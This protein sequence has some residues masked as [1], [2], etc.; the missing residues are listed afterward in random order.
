MVLEQS[1]HPLP[2]DQP[3]L[4]HATLVVGLGLSLLARS[5]LI[6]ILPQTDD[7][8]F[9]SMLL[10]DLFCRNTEVPHNQPLPSIL[11]CWGS[12]FLG[13]NVVV[14]RSFE[15][16]A[17]AATA[18]LVYRLGRTLYD[19]TTGLLACQL[20][21]CLPLSFCLSCIVKTYSLV[22]LFSAAALVFF[23]SALR[24]NS[25]VLAAGSG[26]CVFS[27]FACKNLGAIGIA[28]A[29]IL[30]LVALWR[31]RREPRARRVFALSL[32]STLACCLPLG[33][34]I[35]W[36]LPTYGSSILNDFAISSRLRLWLDARPLPW[37]DFQSYSSILPYV[38]LPALGWWAW[39]HLRARWSDP[40][41]R[42][43]PEPPDRGMESLAP[44]LI[45]AVLLG[46]NLGLVFLNPINHIPRG[47]APSLPI[48][49]LSTAAVLAGLYREAASRRV[50]LSWLLAL[51]GVSCIYPGLFLANLCHLWELDAFFTMATPQ[52]ILL[53]FGCILAVQLVLFALLHLVQRGPAPVFLGRCR[54]GAM[55]VV[56]LSSTLFGI[57][58]GASP[59]WQLG[60]AMQPNLDAL[61]TLPSC[62]VIGGGDAVTFLGYPAFANFHSLPRKDLIRAFS[63]DLEAVLRHYSIAHILHPREPQ[64]VGQ[65][66]LTSI[67]QQYQLGPV[68]LETL[69]LG[70]TD[71]HRIYD[72][73]SVSVLHF[74]AIRSVACDNHLLLDRHRPPLEVDTI[75]ASLTLRAVPAR[76]G[77]WSLTLSNRSNRA[78]T[79]RISFHDAPP[80]QTTAFELRGNAPPL[81]STTSPVASAWTMSFRPADWSVQQGFLVRALQGNR[82]TGLTVFLP[83]AS[84]R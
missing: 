30:T 58:Y 47:L 8:S 55:L 46:S 31:S 24:R 42:P 64:E 59:L 16:L 44:R 7:D 5:V 68:S 13:T 2:S 15:V 57:L 83:A 56:V 21:T 62:R 26:L 81:W 12:T 39:N 52:G 76:P 27:A 17:T 43:L 25:L 82:P 22:M 9:T 11:F 4:L 10:A 70:R 50:A 37:Q 51:A 45:P 73:G 36:R 32:T 78:T 74:P 41:R 19:R 20:F 60:K 1:I 48:L 14:Y 66:I 6:W 3:R 38:F 54:T 72:N 75:E 40:A 77:E 69:L 35:W 34:L 71:Y 61:A 84:C 29:M 18:F 53:V 65:H 63:G 33:L 23:F 28:P 67:A 79:F 49:A 80:E